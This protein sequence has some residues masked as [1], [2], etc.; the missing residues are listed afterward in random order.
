MKTF[1]AALLIAVTATTAQAGLTYTITKPVK[2]STVNMQASMTGYVRAREFAMRFTRVIK[3]DG[4]NT[5]TIGRED[6]PNA[7]RLRVEGGSRTAWAVVKGTSRTKVLLP[8]GVKV[9]ARGLLLP[10]SVLVYMGCGVKAES[11]TGLRVSCDGVTYSL[12]RY[13]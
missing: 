5:Y 6:E 1:L 11:A 4:P 13:R 10:P 9:D 2:V 12:A 8:R 3:R 7:R